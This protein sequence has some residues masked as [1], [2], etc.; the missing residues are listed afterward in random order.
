MAKR[1]ETKTNKP[2]LPSRP[3]IVTIMGHVDHGKTTLLDSIRKTNDAAKEFGGITQTIGAYQVSYQTKEGPK[4]I[5]F[6]DT[7]GHEAFSAMRARGASVTDIV[8]LVVA[9]D[10]GVKPQ[11]VEAIKHAKSAGVPMIVAINKI[12]LPG[13]DPEKVKRELTKAEV[14]TESMGGDTVT[15]LVSAKNGQGIDDLLEMILL[16]AEMRVLTADPNKEFEGIV[17]ESHI[18]TKRGPLVSLIVKSGS[19]S[20]GQSIYSEGVSGKVRAM[21]NEW[22]KPV[23][24]ATSSTPVE[25]IGF[26]NLPP[27][28][29]SVFTTERK[30]TENAEI[31]AET[32]KPEM[33]L[34]TLFAGD[35]KMPGVSVI[36]KADSQGS[37]EAV[38]GSFSRLP[39]DQFELSI[40]HSGVGEVNK[41]DIL[42][43]KQSKALVISYRMKVP[44]AMERLAAEERV[45]AKTYQIIYELLD[46]IEEALWGEVTD[47][48]AAKAIGRAEVIGVFKGTTGSTIAGLKVVEGRLSINDIVVIYRGD[49]EI[50]TG[51]I[52]SLKHQKD[53]VHEVKKGKDC[54]M[55]IEP[56]H[57]FLKG[58]VIEVPS[59]S[60]S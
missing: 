9:A 19:L 40:L 42:L 3:P 7:P 34:Q 39:K 36:I 31:E 4:K 12:D 30:K 43:A 57:E 33:T 14:I 2:T 53:D 26:S 20:I 32:E 22:G 6:I 54:G 25:I 60:S 35:T 8:V 27:L 28:G 58:D 24:I 55:I 18:D 29:A 59:P 37:L 11:T 45:L 47:T 56:D 5:T 44:A 48:I 38:L 46:E 21:L 51:K 23:P 1:K 49:N 50:G 52:K 15:V 41:S 16:T 10:D 13:S 17:I